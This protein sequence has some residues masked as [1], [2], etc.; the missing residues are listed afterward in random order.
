M[1][2]PPLYLNPGGY[3]FGQLNGELITLLGSCVSLCAWHPEKRLLLATHVVLPERP[4]DMLLKDTR[5]GDVVLQS[6][7]ADMYRHKTLISEYKLA[8]FGGSTTI[9]AQDN[10]QSSIGARNVD[11]MRHVVQHVMQCSINKEDIGG[12]QHRRLQIDGIHG[13]F[14]VSLLEKID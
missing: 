14:R 9:Y 3:F 4:A 12:T 13:R 2:K 8:L 11:Y 10:Y 1:S 7:L 5:Y 6:V